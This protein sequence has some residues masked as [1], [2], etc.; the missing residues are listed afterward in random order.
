MIGTPNELESNANE[1]AKRRAPPVSCQRRAVRG[2]RTRIESRIEAAEP[3]GH[4]KRGSVR[5]NVGVCIYGPERRGA[6]SEAIYQCAGSDALRRARA[7]VQPLHAVRVWC[8]CGRLARPPSATV[9]SPRP[10]GEPIQAVTRSGLGEQAG[11]D[12]GCAGEETKR[13]VVLG[14]ERAATVDGTAVEDEGRTTSRRVCR[15]YCGGELD[16]RWLR[17]SRKSKTAET[18]SAAAPKSMRSQLR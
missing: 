4:D 13:G 6:R 1:W 18:I 17:H 5:Q 8:A 14:E 12:N 11:G 9:G 2:T 16:L 3:C 15:R 7:W 10:G